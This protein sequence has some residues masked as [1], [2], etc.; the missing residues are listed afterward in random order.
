VNQALRAAAMLAAGCCVVVAG[1]LVG[2]LPMAWIGRAVVLDLSPAALGAT[3]FG[4]WTMG[5]ALPR[6]IDSG[7]LRNCSLIIFASCIGCLA[8]SAVLPW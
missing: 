8:G 4:L 3:V 6:E 2:I 1:G 7:L 5:V